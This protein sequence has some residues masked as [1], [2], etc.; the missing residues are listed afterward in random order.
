MNK[1]SMIRNTLLTDSIFRAKEI[2]RSINL[3]FSCTSF[4]IYGEKQLEPNQKEAFKKYCCN[5]VVFSYYYY[6]HAVLKF[7]SVYE[8][9]AKFL[10]CKYDFNRYYLDDSK[11]KGMY[12][13]NVIEI[14]KKKGIN[15]EILVKF[16]ECVSSN[17][18]ID[19]EKTRN[20]AYHC[21]R[22]Y[23]FLD[24]KCRDRVIITDI[25]QMT[26]MMY[27]LHELFSMIIEEEKR[28][29]TEMIR[30]KKK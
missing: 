27:S 15:S 12:I 28:I 9:L 4:Y 14:L 10:I 16:Q 25:S 5:D 8:K 17:E 20:K 19:Y 2:I 11:F 3:Y 26:K 7:Y 18:F 13:E 6:D 22:T 29:Y 23:F 21:L 24:E 30:N 1:S